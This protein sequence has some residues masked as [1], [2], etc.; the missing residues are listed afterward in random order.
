MKLGLVIF[1][2]GKFDQRSRVAGSGHHLLLLLRRN[3]GLD[4]GYFHRNLLSF[5]LIHQ[6][7]VP[8]SEPKW[9]KLAP[10][11]WHANE[12]KISPIRFHDIADGG[13]TCRGNW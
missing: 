10:V 2:S 6:R 11:L 12:Q 4:S 1:L 13:V 7:G 3:T 8:G 9:Q 5:L